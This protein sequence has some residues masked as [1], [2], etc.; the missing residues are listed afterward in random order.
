MSDCCGTEGGRVQRGPGIAVGYP[1]T[2]YVR[3]EGPLFDPSARYV[4]QVRR[5]VEDSVLITTLDT[6]N[7]TIVITDE[8]N[9]V[10]EMPASDTSKM[11]PGSVFMDFAKVEGE[12]ERPDSVLPGADLDLD[13]VG[14]EYW[15]EEERI[16]YV[17]IQLEVPV[18][19]PV[20]RGVD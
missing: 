15:A 8:E 16:T 11:R 14:S 18:F 1:W 6:R 9:M 2:L 4:M 13:F 10:L 12:A 19:T 3:A 7:G 17:G 20:T 5:R